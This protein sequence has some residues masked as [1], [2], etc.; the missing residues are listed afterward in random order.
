MEDKQNILTSMSK[1]ELKAMI[2]VAVVE[3]MK[4]LQFQQTESSESTEDLVLIQEASKILRLA[5]PTIY[6]KVS[7]SELP[8]MKRGKLLYFSRKELI[9]YLRDGRRKTKTEIENETKD[10]FLK[11]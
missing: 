10:Y 2:S 1:Q 7:K 3:A 5:V 9:Q 8:Y 4:I 6:S 11:K